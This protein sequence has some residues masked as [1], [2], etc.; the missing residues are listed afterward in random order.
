MYV[1]I[2]NMIA[3]PACTVILETEIR[4]HIRDLQALLS[5]KLSLWIGK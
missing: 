2:I 3:N 4:Y 5:F 1:W